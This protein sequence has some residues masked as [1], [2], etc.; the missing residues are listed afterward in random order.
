[1]FSM[2]GWLHCRVRRDVLLDQQPGQFPTNVHRTLFTL[3]ER[4]QVLLLI[5][6]KH[7]LKCLLR[8]LH[9]L[10]VQTFQITAG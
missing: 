9:P 2:E 10:A 3:T 6:P 8:T 4:D 7:P 5:F 1:M